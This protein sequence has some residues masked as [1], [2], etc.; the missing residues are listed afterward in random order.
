[1]TMKD[2]KLRLLLAGIIVLLPR[3]HAHDN[4]TIHPML[5]DR[6]YDAWSQEADNT[7]FR[8]LSIDPS[9]T[10]DFSAMAGGADSLSKK[11][12]IITAFDKWTDRPWTLKKW[13]IAGA[14]DEDDPNNRCLAHFYNPIPVDGKHALTDPIEVGGRDSFQWATTG[15]NFI[16]PPI[17]NKSPPGA[18]LECWNEARLLYFRALTLPVKQHRESHLAHTFYALG[19]VSHLLQDLSQPDHVRNDAHL[20]DK[21]RWIE[22]YGADNI[23][24]IRTWAE[25]AGVKA[26]DWR[27]ARF[28]RIKDFW[29]RGIY[30]GNPAALDADTSENA[31]ASGAILGLAEFVNGNFL[32]EDASY[33][34][35]TGGNQNFSHPALTDTNFKTFSPLNPGF[36]LK[37]VTWTD[38]SKQ[39]P[40]SGKLRASVFLKKERSGVTVEKHSLLNY[41]T[42]FDTRIDG[43]NENSGPPNVSINAPD[44]LAQYHKTVLPKA[45]QYTAGLLDYFFRGKLEVSIEWDEETG[46]EKLV[47][48]NRSG[49]AI[50]GGVFKLYYDTHD[51]NE[52]RSE[53]STLVVDN[54]SWNNSRI[55][56]DGETINASFEPL[57]V[58][59][60]CM[61]VY[62]GAIGLNENG[63]EAD[64][65]EA[66]HAVAAIH[67]YY[68][69]P[70]NPEP[71][72]DCQSVFA[73]LGSYG[74]SNPADE[75]W[76]IYR[77]KWT[78]TSK[79][80]DGD[81]YISDSARVTGS[82]SGSITTGVEYDINYQGEVSEPGGSHSFTPIGKAIC[83]CVG[84][85]SSANTLDYDLDT[86]PATFET[87]TISTTTKTISNASG[88]ANPDDPPSVYP[89][90]SYRVTTDN[91]VTLWTLVNGTLV[92]VD[93]FPITTKQVVVNAGPLFITDGVVT[94]TG[95]DDHY[96]EGTSLA[97]WQSAARAVI[98]GALDFPT[99][100]EGSGGTLGSYCFS[101]TSATSPAPGDGA[102]IQALKARFRV[103][104]PN[105]PNYGEYTAA[106]AVATALHAAWL[107]GGSIGAEPQI[108][109]LRTVF[110][111]Q[112][113]IGFFPKEWT[114]WKALRD[115]YD[116]VVAQRAAHA[117]WVTEGSHGTEP[118]YPDLP[119]EPGAEP[120]RPSLVTTG[121]WNWGGNPDAPWSEYFTIPLPA[122][123]G[124]MKRVNLMTKGYAGVQPTTWGEVFVFDE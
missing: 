29:D 26:L 106:H 62:K 116:G 73:S 85:Y 15:D 76:K 81:A 119:D 13:L 114:D 93:G 40:K 102:E 63:S 37:A 39:N 53:V 6:A 111:V 75:T 5:T 57:S 32:G 84:E 7:F 66:G 35:V 89:P 82:S 12:M 44:V 92:P 41:S 48:T 56:E 79:V 86:D 104:I 91:V 20:I 78:V 42:V 50:K 124:V 64:P 96:D 80:G 34:E 58:D 115:A 59:S 99:T 47:I 9:D 105:T 2:L 98:M 112:W 61:L 54:G 49:S 83:G 23:T 22:N 25:L 11:D 69:T 55:L 88:D 18:N 36:F 14:I 107:A 21:F 71:R 27:A 8:D 30:N 120:T 72:I 87:K 74:F 46:K 117:V 110:E 38:L 103:G 97:D 17:T 70:T 94:T 123:D 24:R 51:S 4:L 31:A 113:D 100:L 121:S 65:I 108:P 60:E 3:L 45:I 90:C 10:P 68:E 33:E 109:V 118:P 1:M 28:V 77:K 122:T 43:G 16:P 67:F 101:S 19:K 52:T 95:P